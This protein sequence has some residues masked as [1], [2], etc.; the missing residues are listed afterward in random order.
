MKMSKMML[1]GL[2]MIMGG[3]AFAQTEEAKPEKV[4]EVET[5]SFWSNWFVGVSGGIQHYAGDY[6]KLG[7]GSLITGMGEVFVGKWFTPVIGL[8]A[9]AA[10][11]RAKGF[12]PNLNVGYAYQ[13]ENGYCKARWGN[14]YLHGDVMINASNLFC[15]YNPK[16][17]WNAIPFATIGGM[18]VVGDHSGQVELAM[19]AG[20]LNNFRIND[21]WGAHLEVRCVAVPDFYD[22]IVAKKNY[23]LSTQVLVGVQYKLGKTTGWA[24]KG[25]TT[26]A[27]VAEVQKQLA[28]MQDENNS[29][30]GQIST[31][32]NEKAAAL[33][34]VKNASAEAA[35]NEQYNGA[36]YTVFYNI[37]S[38]KLTDKELVNLEA[39]ANKIK[40][41]PNSKFVISGY[42]D[43][44]TGS[45]AYNQKLSEQRAQNVYDTLV[46]KFGVNGD[47]LTVEGKGGVDTMF[48]NNPRMSRASIIEVK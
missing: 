22:G 7:D 42:A 1:L 10:L 29:L 30:K 12:T 18:A 21:K 27:A 9:G 48:Y 35:K 11:Y 45:A 26:A 25:A 23:D 24:A 14:F 13:R 33:E 36:S 40:D 41:Y 17:F 16:R 43:K 28:A 2:A 15:G 20:L 46:N 44:Q 38:S 32:E 6:R 37:N 47:Q 31:L 39:I 8:R 4:Y 5:N 3:T 34:N 19:G